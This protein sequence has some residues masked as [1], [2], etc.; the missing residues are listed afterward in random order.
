MIRWLKFN[1]VGGIG[2]TVQLA[3]LA[4]LKNGLRLNYLLATTLA[5]EAAVIHNFFWHERFTWID[6]ASEN[7]TFHF[8]KFNLTNGALS[9]LG[10]LI[11]MKLFVGILHFQYLIANLTAIAVFSIANFLLSDHFVFRKPV[12]E[13]N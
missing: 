9:I 12:F 11:L 2:I 5:V 13:R 6:R 7:R 4:A 10:N 8:L 3:T 1:L